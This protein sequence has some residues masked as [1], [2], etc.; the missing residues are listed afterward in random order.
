ML[1][2]LLIINISHAAVCRFFL[3]GIR[4]YMLLVS[5]PSS[6]QYRIMFLLFD[7]LNSLCP[8]PIANTF[9]CTGYCIYIRGPDEDAYRY[10]NIL[11][12]S[13]FAFIIGSQLFFVLSVLVT[14]VN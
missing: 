2:N 3:I 10:Y 7:F 5:Y 6:K 9:F 11:S 14:C 12:V 4:Y 13:L 8:L 1:E